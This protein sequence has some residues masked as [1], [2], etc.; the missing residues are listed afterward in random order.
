[1]ECVEDERH[2]T[3]RDKIRDKMGSNTSILFIN[4]AHGSFVIGLRDYQ[5][6]N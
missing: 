2:D 5:G 6:T 3:A 4:S 1:M